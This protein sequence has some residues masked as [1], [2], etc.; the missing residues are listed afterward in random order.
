MHFDKAR[1]SSSGGARAVRALLLGVVHLLIHAWTYPQHF[2]FASLLQVATNEQ[3]IQD[4]V[5]LVEIKDDVKLAHISEVAIQ[6]LY[7]QV[8]LLQNN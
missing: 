1:L 7:E 6:H 5:R 8:D 4:V 2:W 3:F